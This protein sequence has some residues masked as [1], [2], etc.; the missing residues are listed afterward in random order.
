MIRLLILSA[1]LSD[2]SD[3]SHFFRH[4]GHAFGCEP[5]WKAQLPR[6]VAVADTTR[7]RYGHACRSLVLALSLDMPQPEFPLCC[8]CKRFL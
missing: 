6:P 8:G 3:P 5:V 1:P 7:T 2:G 4:V